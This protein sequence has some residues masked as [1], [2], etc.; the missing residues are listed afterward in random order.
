MQRVTGAS[1]E[2]GGEIVSSIEVGIVVLLGFCTGDTVLKASRLHQ[3]LLTWRVFKD[4]GGKMNLSIRDVGGS[5]LVIPQFTVYGD[6][7]GRRPHFLNAMPPNEAS[8]LF[9]GVISDWA[10]HGVPLKTGIFGADM[11]VSIHNHGPVTWCWDE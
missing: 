8:H 7:S 1:V 2:V 11:A 10:S 4:E 6:F 3:R 9:E 5:L